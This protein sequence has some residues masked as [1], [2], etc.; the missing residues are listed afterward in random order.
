MPC[1]FNVNARSGYPVY[2]QIVQQV[3]RAI[4]IGALVPGEQLPTIKQLSRDLV[5]NPSTVVKALQE[6]EHLGV[7]TTL[8]G[9]GSYVSER[10]TDVSRQQS[11]EII[12]GEALERA[13]S[14]AQSLGI[15]GDVVRQLFDRAF[16]ARYLRNSKG[17][18]VP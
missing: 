5:V 2:L 12:V 3:Q 9:R 7:I 14:D 6:L 18:L 17:E 10:A 16:S 1:T 13:V 4:A 11:A 15:D 8:P